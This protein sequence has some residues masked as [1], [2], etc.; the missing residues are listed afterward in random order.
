[1]GSKSELYVYNLDICNSLSNVTQDFKFR[2]NLHPYKLRMASVTT[3]TFYAPLTTTF[4]APAAC[5]NTPY[6]LRIVPTTWWKQ[7][8]DLTESCFPPAFPFTIS[9]VIYSPGVCPAGWASACDEAVTTSGSTQTI[10]SCC[11]AQ[12][13]PVTLIDGLLID[14]NRYFQCASTSRSVHDWEDEYGCASSYSIDFEKWAIKSDA[15]YVPSMYQVPVMI[16]S[17]KVSAS[18]QINIPAIHSCQVTST[19]PTPT[20]PASPGLT[21]SNSEPTGAT[22]TSPPS[23]TVAN[24][25]L[26]KGAIVGIIIG[27]IIGAAMVIILTYIALT[28]RKK[29][30]MNVHDSSAITSPPGYSWNAPYI[31]ELNDNVPPAEMEAQGKPARV[32]ELGAPT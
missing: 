3:P 23:Q 12:V 20:T 17:A 24:N 29:N 10:I 1:M 5:F 26:S 8:G 22:N 2:A 31:A 21:L 30:R 25:G 28:I 18:S 6:L 27:A 11:P 14:Q 13:E 4:T 32:Y 15:A 7:G 16:M 19:S 9:R